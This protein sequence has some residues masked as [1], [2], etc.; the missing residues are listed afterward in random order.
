MRSFFL[1]SFLL[2]SAVAFAQP[3][4]ITQA[5]VNTTTNVIAPD[6]ED[7]SQ[8]QNQGGGGFNFRNMGDG[9]TKTVTYIKNDLV[10]T[11][12]KSESFRGSIFRDNLSKTTT[13]IFE[14]MGNK[15]GIK[16]SDD[17]QAEMI[18]KM[19]STMKERAKK[20][21]SFHYK[22]RA[23]RTPVVPVI[24]YTEESKKIA[25]YEC[26]KAYIITDR[27]LGKDSLAVWYTPEIK[28][29]NLASTGGTSGL[30]NFGGGNNFDNIN[31]FVMQYEKS[32]PRGRK[33]EVK[34]TKIEIT[35]VDDKEFVLP[36][37]VEIKTM[38]EMSEGGGAGMMRMMQRN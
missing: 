16:A 29:P 10:K 23:V 33:M 36:K 28:F 37:D 7:V 35:N 21:T 13:T 4:V 26:R 11:N 22:P 30:G 38:K 18:K 2:F 9:E 25:G 24:S 15:Q 1:F 17:D 14:I 3:K 31:G 27:L 32:M 12:F 20:D 5:T 19:D 34:V 6:D 8:I